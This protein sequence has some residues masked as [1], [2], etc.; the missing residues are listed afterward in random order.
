MFVHMYVYCMIPCVPYACMDLHAYVCVIVGMCASA[1]LSEQQYRADL[2]MEP[3]LDIGLFHAR[4]HMYSH[5]FACM[6]STC[7]ST[8]GKLTRVPALLPQRLN[9]SML[10]SVKVGGV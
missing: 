2:V 9:N 8:T 7:L 1:Q 6:L 10:H 3:F 5:T 4:K